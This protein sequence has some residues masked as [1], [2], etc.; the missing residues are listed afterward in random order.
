M[1][2]F[3][4]G[5]T[6]VGAAYNGQQRGMTVNAFTAVSLDPQMVLICIARESGCHELI[7]KSGM[8]SVSVLS[9]EQSELSGKFADHDEFDVRRF[10][11][12]D[13]H[14]GAAGVPIVDGAVAELEYTVKDRLPAGDHTIFVGTVTAA[15]V[16]SDKDPLIFYQ[17]RYARIGTAIV[18]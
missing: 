15:Q 9:E 11:S 2:R 3:P 4:T 12:V 6:V 8:S 17:S 18:D 13:H 16:M 7:E 10:V 14:F 5:V 1:K